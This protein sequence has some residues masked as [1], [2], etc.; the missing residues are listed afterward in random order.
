MRRLSLAFFDNLFEQIPKRDNAQQF[1]AV[2]EESSRPEG[3]CPL[4]IQ[5]RPLTVGEIARVE[6]FD[7]LDKLPA[8]PGIDLARGNI[9][10]EALDALSKV[11]ASGGVGGWRLSHRN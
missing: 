1:D 7:R 5:H 8:F 10:E 9:V 4:R 11:A 2:G 3:L 6:M